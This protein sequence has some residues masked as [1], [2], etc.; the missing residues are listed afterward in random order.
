MTANSTPK[1]NIGDNVIFTLN[2]SG[3]KP[4]YVVE[5]V[6][7]K[8]ADFFTSEG[9]Y[10]CFANTDLMANEKHLQLKTS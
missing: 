3:K 7:Y 2:L 10:Y 5:S 4:H 9:W 1:Y 8:E 6:H